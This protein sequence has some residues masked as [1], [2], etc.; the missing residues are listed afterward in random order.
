MERMIARGRADDTADAISRRLALYHSETT[1]LLVHYAKV[2]I[3][4]DGVG[5]VEEIQQRA[6]TALQR[7]D[8][9]AGT[10]TA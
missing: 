1:P 10:E 5:S 8:P 7:A 6:L 2:L 3:A 4:I 9:D